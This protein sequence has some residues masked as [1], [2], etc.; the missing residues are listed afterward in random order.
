MST[1]TPLPKAEHGSTEQTT[2]A[3][4]S[5]PAIDIGTQTVHAALTDEE[6]F[7]P[8]TVSPPQTPGYQLTQQEQ[9]RIKALD[10]EIESLKDKQKATQTL[11]QSKLDAYTLLAEKASAH[12]ASV[13]PTNPMV[14]LMSDSYR[15]IT[16]LQEEIIT[17]KSAIATLR[18]ESYEINIGLRQGLP[19]NTLDIADV[20]APL[21]NQSAIETPRGATTMPSAANTGNAGV[22]A[23][24]NAAGAPVVVPISPAP[25]LRAAS[26]IKEATLAHVSAIAPMAPLGASPDP[27]NPTSP[28]TAVIEKP[29]VIASSHAATLTDSQPIQPDIPGHGSTVINSSSGQAQQANMAPNQSEALHA[30]NANE[31]IR[32]NKVKEYINSGKVNLKGKNS[33]NNASTNLGTNEFP[34]A[35][36]NKNNN[37]GYD[38]KSTSQGNVVVTTQITAT[39]FNNFLT[40]QC[41]LEIEKNNEDI[42]TRKSQI[43]KI[44]QELEFKD[45]Q[46][47]VTKLGLIEKIVLARQHLRSKG[48]E[49][50]Y[51]M[52]NDEGVNK[53]KYEFTLKDSTGK[54]EKKFI[55]E[56]E[57]NGYAAQQVAIERKN[58]QQQLNSN[59]QELLSTATKQSEVLLMRLREADQ[60]LE[61]L[62]NDKKSANLNENDGLDEILRDDYDKRIGKAQSEFNRIKSKFQKVDAEIESVRK[63]INNSTVNQNNALGQPQPTI[64]TTAIPPTVQH[65]EKIAVLH[66]TDPNRHEAKKAKKAFVTHEQQAQS[67]SIT[68]PITPLHQ[69]QHAIIVSAGANIDGARESPTVSR[70]IDDTNLLAAIGSKVKKFANSPEI[71]TP[72]TIAL[73]QK[74]ITVTSND[75]NKEIAFKA[76]TTSVSTNT[77]NDKNLQ[78]MSVALVENLKNKLD[79]DHSATNLA[80]KLDDCKPPEVATKFAKYLNA[81][82]DNLKLERPD[83]AARVKNIPGPTPIAAVSLTSANNITPEPVRD[84]G[85]PS[86]AS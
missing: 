11:L 71:Q 21:P 22:V 36:I 1:P 67:F 2:V 58:L 83:L 6:D 81:E 34:V 24:S 50:T 53:G 66:E 30:K 60:E 17:I 86:L 51:S 20:P 42:A 7:I 25:V 5:G 40:K 33:E 3:A 75:S 74:E 31:Q 48:I 49:M 8:Y 56:E 29:Q 72:V 19:P 82:L 57:L 14:D 65:V 70:T 35:E 27:K 61:R 55:R 84:P 43:A 76:T 23:S 4:T 85:A 10:K 78:A 63:S 12:D 68:D 59:R 13:Q 41:D 54:T 28:A 69:P 16:E 18:K 45:S 47:D 52:V 77:I 9:T 62:K 39:L 46:K 32:I 15:K 38:I 73:S 44:E 80:I 79:A 64:D 26:V 37:G